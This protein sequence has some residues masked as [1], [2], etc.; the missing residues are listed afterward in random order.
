MLKRD[1]GSPSTKPEDIKHDNTIQ[2][3]SHHQDHSMSLGGLFRQMVSIRCLNMTSMLSLV[4][5]ALLIDCPIICPNMQ[6][7]SIE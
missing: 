2:I 3:N 7:V 4:E 6:P 1:K 5:K